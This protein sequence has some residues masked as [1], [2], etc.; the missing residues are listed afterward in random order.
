VNETTEQDRT[1]TS[2]AR[3]SRSLLSFGALLVVFG[4]AVAATSAIA[5]APDSE[6]ADGQQ[7][8]GGV[9]VLAGWAVLVWGIHRFGRASPA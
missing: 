7:L 4:L 5:G 8:V 6:N 1:P 9:I 3:T 2:K